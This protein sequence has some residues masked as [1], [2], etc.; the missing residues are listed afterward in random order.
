MRQ[1]FRR[2][3]KGI[4]VAGFFVLNILKAVVK[5][6]EAIE[7]FDSIYRY[8]KRRRACLLKP[9]ELADLFTGI[10]EAP[11]S[12]Q[13]ANY[14]D[15]GISHLE[16]YLICAIVRHIKAKN[17]FEIGTFDGTTTLHLA[18]NSEADARIFT[19][20]LPQSLIS[21]T[22]FALL[23]SDKIYIDKS[24]PGERFKGL[25]LEHKIEQLLG[26]SAT[27]DFSPFYQ[28]MDLVFVDGSHQYEYVKVDSENAFKMLRPGGV[29][30]WHDYITFDGVTKFVEELSHEESLYHIK[31]TSLVI[32][33]G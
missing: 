20:D 3:G 15:G 25:D 6:K 12:F 2:L 29:I 13:R 8:A 24:Q 4:Y 27:F 28:K 32:F 1:I 30:I 26:D 22:K 10:Y 33:I 7:F 17:M 16:L 5:P 18:L 14:K 9:I 21:D 19:L 11:V 23:E 31:D